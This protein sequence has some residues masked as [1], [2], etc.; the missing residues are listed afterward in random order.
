[1]NLK[2]LCLEQDAWQKFTWHDLFRMSQI[3]DISEMDGS[4]DWDD[5][6]FAYERRMTKLPNYG[7]TDK[8]V[9]VYIKKQ[10]YDCMSLGPIDGSWDRGFNLVGTSGNLVLNPWYAMCLMDANN[11]LEV[12][13]TTV[14]GGITDV[15]VRWILSELPRAVLGAPGV[16]AN[17]PAHGSQLLA[18][19]VKF[20]EYQFS[21]F[22]KI[23]AAFGYQG[24]MNFTTKPADAIIRIGRMAYEASITALR[25][26]AGAAPTAAQILNANQA[27]ERFEG[28]ARGVD[29]PDLA[30]GD[31]YNTYL[32]DANCV[33][34]MRGHPDYRHRSYHV[35]RDNFDRYLKLYLSGK[36]DMLNADARKFF[37]NFNW[38]RFGAG[39]AAVDRVTVFAQLLARIYQV[40]RPPYSY[41]N[42]LDGGKIECGAVV[43]VAATYDQRRLAITNLLQDVEKKRH[44]LVVVRPNIEHNMLGIIMGRGG[45][46]ELGATFWGQ[47]ELSCYDDSMHGEFCLGSCHAC[48][49]HAEIV[50]AQASGV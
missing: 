5:D 22:P 40:D 33:G 13:T 32:N 30:T 4:A 34:S 37:D 24:E 11:G 50:R 25:L 17:Y 42:E 18:D 43:G 6:N 14:G 31:R 2:R 49:N 39:I 45:L 9:D 15:E 44:E 16:I 23:L 10:L 36:A 7:I 19:P 20:S 29:F 28:Y 27:K 47:T 21:E 46:E 48:W 38:Q 12:P 26:A 35:A 41:Y 3:G 1:M 8:S